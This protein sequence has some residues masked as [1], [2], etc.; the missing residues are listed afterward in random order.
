MTINK[1]ARTTTAHLH[2]SL[3]LVAITTVA[4]RLKIGTVNDQH[5]WK[6]TSGSFGTATWPCTPSKNQLFIEQ[7][8]TL[9]K[10]TTYHIVQNIS[11][12]S[13]DHNPLVYDL[14]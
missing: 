1:R 6:N 4:Y 5:I 13:S 12:L 2:R 3:S 14:G 7:D 11:D 8:F 9:S 10:G